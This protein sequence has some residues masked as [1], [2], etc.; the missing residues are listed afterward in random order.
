MATINPEQL[1]D[2]E[3]DLD[4]FEW[5]SEGTM[6]KIDSVEMSDFTPTQKQELAEVIKSFQDV[7]NANPGRTSVSE[8]HIHVAEPTPIHQ[9]LYCL[10]YSRREVVEEEVQKMVEAKVIHP[11][12]SPWASPIMR[13]EKKDGTV[14]FCMDYRKV[15]SVTKLV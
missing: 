3:F 1:E 14:R 2:S 4:L 12:C 10:P 6:E 7:F 8:H 9:K 13:V 11:S 15:N 5:T